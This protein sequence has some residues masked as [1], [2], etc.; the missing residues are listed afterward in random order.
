[1]TVRRS[2]A[3]DIETFVV[4]ID[5]TGVPHLLPTGGRG[6]RQAGV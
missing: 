1:L 2:G 5:R 4:Q 6:K 3:T